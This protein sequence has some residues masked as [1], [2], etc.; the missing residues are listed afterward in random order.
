MGI[1]SAAVIIF[2]VLCLLARY[3]TAK[4]MANMTIE[5]RE[6]Y[7]RQLKATR[8]PPIRDERAAKQEH[9]FAKK[10]EERKFRGFEVTCK[11]KQN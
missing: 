8:P 6:A 4:A 2:V 3:L 11:K 10:L 5:E 7:K 9:K 1:G